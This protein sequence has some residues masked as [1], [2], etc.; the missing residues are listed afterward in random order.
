MPDDDQ[1][2]ELP[3]HRIPMSV[4]TAAIAGH[5]ERRN[6]AALQCVKYT[7]LGGPKD[8]QKAKHYAEVADAAQNAIYRL[9]TPE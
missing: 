8:K 9:Q 7:L 5:M 4:R 3:P 6:W 2:K 1:T